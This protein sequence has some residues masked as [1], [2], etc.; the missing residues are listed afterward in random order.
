MSVSGFSSGSF[1]GP[2][3]N[4]K[5]SSVE[6]YK[7]LSTLLLITLKYIENNLGTRFLLNK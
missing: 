4:L 7:I 6:V 3:Y 5:N 2:Q 1:T